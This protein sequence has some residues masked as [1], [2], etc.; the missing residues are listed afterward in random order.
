MQLPNSHKAVVEIEKLREYSLNP[1][2]PVGKHKHESSR[3]RSVLPYKMRNGYANGA[4]QRFYFD[5]AASIGDG[6]RLGKPSPGATLLKAR[7]AT[8]QRLSLMVNL[9][10]TSWK[11]YGIAEKGLSVGLAAGVVRPTTE[12]RIASA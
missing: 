6:A 4:V 9:D 7:M 3:R 1:T 12:N 5:H 2:H 10:F 11:E 8:G